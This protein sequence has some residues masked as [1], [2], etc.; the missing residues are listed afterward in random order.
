MTN[1]SDNQKKRRDLVVSRTFDAPVE[2]AWKLW[3]DP[4]QVKTWWGPKDYTS[5]TCEL[6]L[7][8][9]GKYLFCM[10]SSG[11]EGS[12]DFYSTGTFTRIVPMERLEFTQSFADENGNMIAAADFGMPDMPDEVRTVVTFKD[13]GGGKTEMTI[14]QYDQPDDEMFNY[15]VTGWNESFDKMAEGLKTN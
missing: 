13:A 1:K 14:T 7:R 15:A 12:Q 9:G 2:L 5:P 6:D 11:A 4:E 3:T 10:R 8:E